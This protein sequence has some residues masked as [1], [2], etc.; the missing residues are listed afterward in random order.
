VSWSFCRAARPAPRTTR[1]SGCGGTA[2]T[3]AGT[4]PSAG[5]LARARLPRTRHSCCSALCPARSLH[6][7]ATLARPALL[8]AG[9]VKARARAQRHSARATVRWHC[10]PRFNCKERARRRTRADSRFSAPGTARSPT[11]V[12]RARQARRV[13]H[14]DRPPRCQ[15]R[16]PLPRHRPP[17]LT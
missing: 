15:P 6:P 16:T 7:H 2:P 11:R 13:S 10:R 12:S 3:G 17:K 14:A 1:A 5:R 9:T 8:W 4:R